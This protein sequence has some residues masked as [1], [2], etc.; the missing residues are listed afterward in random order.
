VILLQALAIAD[1]PTDDADRR[2]RKRIGVVAGYVTVLAPLTLVLQAP[3]HPLT[4][5]LALGLSLFSVAN[6]V[7]LAR[8]HDFD[9][10]VVAL[11]A[12]GTVFVPLAA[13]VGGGIT[14][15]SPG[16][17][18]A[19][20]IPAY[21]ILA[22]GPARA[23]PWFVAFLLS[24]GLTVAIDPLVRAASVE[25]PYL[26]RLVGQTQNVVLPLTIT[27]VMLRYSDIRRRRAEARVDELLTNAI[28]ASIASRLK[29]GETLIADR[30]PATTVLFADIVGFTP[31]TART[32]PM[33]SVTLLDAL[34][35]A[36]DAAAAE[37]GLEKIRSIGDSFMAVAGAP[38]A[39]DDHARAAVDLARSI[40][41][42]A[43]AWREAHGLDLQLR[44]GLASGPVVG[45]VIG[46]R[47]ML[48]D[49]WGE[50]VN[51]AAR[52]ESSGVP[53]RVHL[54]PTTWAA[55]GGALVVERREIDVKGMG[56]M[57]TY[58]LVEPD[59][60]PGIDAEVRPTPAG[61]TPAA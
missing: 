15:S 44:V 5:P 40:L 18:W 21:A 56:P 1:D 46:Q 48:F 30:Y 26:L 52:M 11:I 42:A 37:H 54:A 10:Y 38:D 33:R 17:V 24:I 35:G 29:A 2:L 49:V 28:P 27:F 4:W 58:L 14:G 47:R 12:S 22:L 61:R 60:T 7:V 43:A 59:P 55:V 57:T 51:T 39:R 19:F 45:G 31:W 53:G 8:R 25:A 36:L 13:L 50:T 6:L 32:D 34:F 41:R 3:G 20:L 16:L 23:T 9:G